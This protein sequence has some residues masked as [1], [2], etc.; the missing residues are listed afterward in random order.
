LNLRAPLAMTQQPA[1]N[2]GQAWPTLI[3][4]PYTAFLDQTT[5]VSIFGGQG[6]TDSFWQ[7]VGPHEIAHQWWG[8]IL[9]WTSY[10]DQWM[11]EG[12]SEFSASLYI[13]FVKKDLKKFIDF[14]EEQRKYIV[15]PQR[16][17]EGKKPYTI[18]S[19]TQG[20]RLNSAKTGNVARY[21]IYPKGAYILHM[22]R[23]MMFDQR[24]KTDPDARF[25]AMMQDFIKSYFNK[26]VSTLDFKR[27]VDKHMTAEMD[28]GG[29]KRSDWFFAQWVYGKEV[30]A[31]QFDYSVADAGGKP[32]L[33]GRITQS[34][35]PDNFAM[36]VPVYVDYG[37]GW[38]KL[39]N[40]TI[41]GNSSVDLPNIPLAAQPKRVAICALNDVLATSIQNNKR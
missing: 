18:G 10:H 38:T 13:Q 21:M 39:G 11:S 26:D 5:R 35:V 37:R 30:P 29:N 9:G 34:G 20:Y 2:F 31:Y 17:T 36:L 8:H 6:G 33:S 16:D 23:M 7:Y 28:L 3:F 4:M 25:K 14:W 24:S 12:F 41:V 15:E 22:L 32:G 19:V 1:G 27:I 40:A